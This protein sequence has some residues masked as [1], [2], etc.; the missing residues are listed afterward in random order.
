M[1]TLKSLVSKIALTLLCVLLTQFVQAQDVLVLKN[2]DRITGEISRI[3]DNEV[4]IEPE[5]SDEFQVDLPVVDYIESDREFEIDLQD[6]S[7]VRASFGGANEDGTQIITTSIESL[8]ITLASISELDEID[9]YYDWESHV[10]LS[11]NLNKGNTDSANTKLRADGMFKHGDHRHR[12]EISFSREEL[13]GQLTQEQDRFSYNYNWLFNDPW[14]FTANLNYER[15][16][17][18]ELDSRLVV[19]AGIGHDIWNTPRKYL[20]TQLGAGLQTEEI[21]MESQQSSVVV[22]GLRFR[23]D[24][25]GDDLSVFNNLTITAN[26]SGR[27]N[28]SYRTSTGISYEITDLLYTSASVDYDYDTDPVETAKSE[29]ISIL[30]GLGLEFE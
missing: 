13:S 11:G 7:S 10:D 26:V 21:G 25:F 16:P 15:D 14:F 19:S 20:T 1:K 5:Y 3:W 23:R 24:F 30:F 6:G 4:T 27:T 17:I 2:G 22:W 9:A 28:T 18:I 29:D 8:E 12:G